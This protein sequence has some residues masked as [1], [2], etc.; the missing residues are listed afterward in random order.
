M[1]YMLADIYVPLFLLF[2]YSE[3][4]IINKK[5]IIVHI[6]NDSMD[7]LDVHTTLASSTSCNTGIN[8]TVII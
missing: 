8:S 2:F 4:I 5:S 6:F 7:K 3:V 1:K